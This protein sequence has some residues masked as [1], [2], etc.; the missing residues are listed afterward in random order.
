MNWI[1]DGIAIWNNDC[2]V[3]DYEDCDS[4]IRSWG[5]WSEWEID[6][7]DPHYEYRERTV[8]IVDAVDS[9]IQCA[10]P[11][12]Q[13]EYQYI[14]CSSTYRVYTTWTAWA[15][16]QN[17]LT[18]EFRT[19]EVSAVDSLN[20]QLI[21]AGPITETE[22]R[23]IEE[24]YDRCSVINTEY[25]EWSEWTL[26]PEDDTQEFR[27]RTFTDYDSENSEYV[28]N[29]DVE[30]EYRDIEDEGDVLGESDEKG[31]VL[32]TSIVSADT[33]G[34]SNPIINIIEYLLIISTGISFI[35]LGKRKLQLK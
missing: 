4:T 29:E 18:Q 22:Y 21:C 15:V 12:V 11:I 13:R 31:E 8:Y 3:L 27:T 1:E 9:T 23:D 24:E 35:F 5:E 30:I 19:R 33:A 20:S 2:K 10:E 7:N 16:D 34:G 26:D 14:P 6:P 17:D 28:C 25:G 32:G